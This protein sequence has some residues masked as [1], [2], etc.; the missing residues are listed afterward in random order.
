MWPFPN[1]AENKTKKPNGIANMKKSACLLLDER[2]QVESNLVHY[3]RN[4]EIRGR[5][6]GGTE[7]AC[8]PALVM[9]VGRQ[10]QVHVFQCRSANLEIAHGDF[11]GRGPSM[12]LGQ[13][14]QRVR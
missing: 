9:L 4:S 11:V 6:V 2:D 10:G 5:P 3:N 7:K 8:V 12:H 13:A 14:L 1:I